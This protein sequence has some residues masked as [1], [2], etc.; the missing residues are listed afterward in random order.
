MYVHIVYVLTFN[1]FGFVFVR[2]CIEKFCVFTLLIFSPS[3]CPVAICV[4][5]YFGLSDLPGYWVFNCFMSCPP[6]VPSLAAWP[7]CSFP[8]VPTCA[9]LQA[10]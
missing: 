5:L 9:F 10:S 4:F 2:E 8:S 6:S 1:A 3:G 7:A